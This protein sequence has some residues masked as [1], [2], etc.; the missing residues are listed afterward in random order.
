MGD[1]LD[2]FVLSDIP[3]YR[4]CGAILT[5]SN[6]RGN[7][8]AREQLPWQSGPPDPSPRASHLCLFRSRT[9][10]C[11]CNFGAFQSRLTTSHPAAPVYFLAKYRNGLGFHPS[12][13]EPLIYSPFLSIL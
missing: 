13:K 12:V 2:E 11:A 10:S 5:A 9:R 8:G 6:L 4:N 3:D 1:P 7:K